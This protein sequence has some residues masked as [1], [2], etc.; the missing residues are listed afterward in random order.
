MKYTLKYT[1]K[2]RYIPSGMEKVISMTG[3]DLYMS[4]ENGKFYAVGFSGKRTPNDFYYAFKTA[5][6]RADYVAKWENEIKVRKESKI[7][8]GDERRIVTTLKVGD[9]LDSM[10]GYDQTNVDF[11][12][13]TKILGTRKIEITPIRGSSPEGEDGFMTGM[14]IAVRDAFKGEPMTKITN[15]GDSVTLTSYS[16][17]SL[18]NGKPIRYS[19]YA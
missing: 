16:S 3:T 5:D 19:W 9:I 18:W 1:N 14:K 11:Y 13:V 17:A 6:N 12:Q 10:W 4:T 2:T 7:K 8:R 15:Y